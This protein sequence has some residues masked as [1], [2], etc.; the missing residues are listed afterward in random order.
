TPVEDPLRCKLLFPVR[1]VAAAAVEGVRG[2]GFRRSSRGNDAFQETVTYA[3]TPSSPRLGSFDRDTKCKVAGDDRVGPRAVGDAAAAVSVGLTQ[4]VVDTVTDELGAARAAFS[5]PGSASIKS[6]KGVLGS[7]AL[8]WSGTNFRS[9]LSK[10]LH[11]PSCIANATA[12]TCSGPVRK[13]FLAGTSVSPCSSA[14]L[15]RS[16][17]RFDDRP[18]ECHIKHASAAS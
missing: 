15:M 13:L 9:W 16:R 17:R 5:V 6:A 8:S 1:V 3:C 11:G 4:E 12:N 2:Q 10:E 7:G 18:K 14:I